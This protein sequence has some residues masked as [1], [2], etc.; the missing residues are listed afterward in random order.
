M[1]NDFWKVPKKYIGVVKQAKGNESCNRIVK[2]KIKNEELIPKWAEKEQ[3]VYVGSY[4]KSS[5]GSECDVSFDDK[6]MLDIKEKVYV[7]NFDGIVDDLLYERYLEIKQPLFTKLP[8]PY[9]SIPVSVRNFIFN[10]LIKLKKDS[11]YPKWPVDSSA[12][13]LRF[14]F[15]NSLKYF[16]KKE[17]PHVN[18]WPDKK[19]GMVVAHD[20]E[21]ESGYENIEKFREIERKYGIKSSWNIVSKRGKID[22]EKLKNLKKEGCEIGCQGYNHDGKLPYLDEK[23]IKKRIGFCLLKLK[24]FDVK[25][26][27][28]PQ[29]Q[30]NEEFLKMLGNHFD[31]DSSVPD[32]EFCS[33][34]AVRNGATTVFPFFIGKM[35]EVPLTMPQDFFM[36]HI[37]KYDSN[38]VFQIWKSKIDY[39][40]SVGGLVSFNIHP[41]SYISGN[42]E[43][44]NLYEKIIRYVSKFDDC[45]KAL[46]NEVAL[47]WRERNNCF[48][49]DNKVIGSERASVCLEN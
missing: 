16:Y 29:L 21:T 1:I 10:I 34:V 37:Y 4:D 33:P 5:V 43:Y 47:W 35:V 38:K 32:T 30:R 19:F 9:H 41:D 14:L 15:M 20:I 18:F 44:L 17:I 12:D 40:R 3:L 2:L 31:Y 8:F 49:K 26:F 25:G 13:L 6:C 36:R 22:F 48:I 11:G 24:E 23:E 27:R 7:N 46:P 42:E 28:S 45:W 39:I